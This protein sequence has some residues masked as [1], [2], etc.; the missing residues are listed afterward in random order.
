M[1]VHMDLTINDLT[2]DLFQS[3]PLKSKKIDNDHFVL[4][5]A[6]IFLTLPCLPMPSATHASFIH[7]SLLLRLPCVGSEKRS[8]SLQ[9]KTP[10]FIIIFTHSPLNHPYPPMWTHVPCIACDVIMISL[11]DKGI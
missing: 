5:K 10:Q 2:N 4:L 1:Y 6:T 11:N 3:F 7:K 9:S 8:M